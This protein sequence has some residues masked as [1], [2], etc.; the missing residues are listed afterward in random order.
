MAQ[1][2]GAL[3]NNIFPGST[4]IIHCK[5][6]SPGWHIPPDAPTEEDKY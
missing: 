6:H 3:N 2:S 1:E 4:N 5:S